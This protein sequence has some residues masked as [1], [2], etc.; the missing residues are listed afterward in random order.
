MTRVNKDFYG[1]SKIM[2]PSKL[3]E[4][5]LEFYKIKV[6]DLDMRYIR[7]GHK[8][9]DNPLTKPWTSG[10]RPKPRFLPK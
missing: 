5:L 6:L 3:T 1:K 7:S 9:Y 10:L 2:E 8:I 4:I